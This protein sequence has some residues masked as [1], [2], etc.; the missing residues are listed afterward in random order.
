[1]DEN[2]P[3][4]D[5]QDELARQIQQLAAVVVIW[6]PISSASGRTAPRR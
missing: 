5:W 2:M 1:V 3:G 6:T 4:V